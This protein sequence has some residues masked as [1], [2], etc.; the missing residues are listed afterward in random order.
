MHGRSFPDV[1]TRSYLKL[2]RAFPLRRL[3]SEADLDGAV[4]V[5][6][7]LLDRGR[8]DQG[9]AAYL[10]VLGDLVREYES[11]HHSI[12][13]KI[14]DREILAY[15]IGEKQVNQLE[16][17]KAT[18]IAESTISAVLAGKRE[19]TRDH[20]GKLAHYFGVGTGVFSFGN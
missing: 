11:V 19:L 5:I 20:I 7:N 8:L 3:K 17:A 10:D 16:V 13:A 9:E 6:D 1:A 4:A 18:G 14:A 12:D 15:L 2:V